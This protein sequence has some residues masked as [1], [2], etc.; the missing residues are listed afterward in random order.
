MYHRAQLNSLESQTFVTL[1]CCNF[2]LLLLLLHFLP[3][4]LFLL[5]LLINRRPLLLLLEDLLVWAYWFFPW[6][7]VMDYVSTC[8]SFHQCVQRL[9]F[10]ACIRQ[11]LINSVSNCQLLVQN[12]DY[13]M[14]NKK[15][16][17]SENNELRRCRNYNIY[18]FLMLWASILIIFSR[19]TILLRTY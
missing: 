12:R 4:L 11:H 17:N 5:L 8:Y 3:L 15:Q 1:Y 13:A 18:L 9:H 6:Y 19:S 2:L 16:L 7:A 14:E 10:P